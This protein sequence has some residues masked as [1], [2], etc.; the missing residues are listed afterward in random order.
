M[1]SVPPFGKIKLLI[2]DDSLFF[3]KSLERGLSKDSRI[4][5][6]G[7]AVDPFDAME[8]IKK[9]NPDVVTL[10]VEMP[11]LNGIDFLK[12]L[13]P[14]HPLPV[15]VVSSAPVSALDALE[16]GAVDFV[17]KPEIKS[18]Q[19]L[20]HFI[21]DLIVKIKIAATAK[22]PTRRAPA[23]PVT[24]SVR[25]TP[26]MPALSLASQHSNTNT[27]IAIGASTGGTEAI[28]AV[29]RDL[30]P[31]TPGIVIVQHMPPVF[32]NMYAQR[33]DR[34]CRMR[35]KEAENNDRVVPGQVII[36][37]GGLQ[38]RLAKDARGY[39]V[40]S[41]GS[42]KIGGFCP[43]VDVLFNSVAEVAGR[44][45]MGVILTGMGADGS[46]GLLKM[47]KAGAYTVGQDQE[48][49]VVY[50]MPMVAF[51][52]GAVQKQFPLDKIGGEIM[53]YLNTRS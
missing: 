9:L 27:I 2:V 49:C 1:T 14:I 31:T 28:L 44:N 35:V 5:I 6:I 42:E 33:L 23:R 37:A 17:K 34:I 48:S 32:T 10:D 11:K 36:G 53:R 7:M 3:R 39:Y 47:R 8:K 19:D 46:K 18:S 29:I 40:K 22:I 13:M 16:A 12:K 51:N 25:T 21:D 41:E 50:G 43:A 45:A 24:A 26:V 38:L 15:V 30:P 52:I 20:N 4:E